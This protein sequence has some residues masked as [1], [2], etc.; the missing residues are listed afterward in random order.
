MG[1]LPAVFTQL[2]ARVPRAESTEPAFADAPRPGPN[3]ALSC[4]GQFKEP[5]SASP[6]PSRNCLLFHRSPSLPGTNAMKICFSGATG[7][8]QRQLLL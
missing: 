6:T 7:P 4:S 2:L 1:R 5:A 8:H 3:S